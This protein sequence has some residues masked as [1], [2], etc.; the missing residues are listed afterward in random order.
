[1]TEKNSAHVPRHMYATKQSRQLQES[2]NKLN[3][4]VEFDR[5]V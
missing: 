3:T 1:M 4:R 5:S 2:K